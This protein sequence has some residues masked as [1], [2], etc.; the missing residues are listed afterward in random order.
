MIDK[1]RA[2]NVLNVYRNRKWFMQYNTSWNLNYW[3][4]ERFLQPKQIFAFSQGCIFIYEKFLFLYLMLTLYVLVSIIVASF[5]HVWFVLKRCDSDGWRGSGLTRQDGKHHASMRLK[6]RIDVRWSGC[7]GCRQ[8][9]RQQFTLANSCNMCSCTVIHQCY[10]NVLLQYL[11]FFQETIY[12]FWKFIFDI[13]DIL[14]VNLMLL[15]E[16]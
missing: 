14:R 4:C 3:K 5:Y 2:L 1:T 16:F 11:V 12:F 6:S 15:N 9:K 13:S 7:C 8:I 10:C